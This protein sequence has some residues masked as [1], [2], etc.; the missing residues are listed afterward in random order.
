VLLDSDGNGGLLNSQQTADI[1]LLNGLAAW[2]ATQGIYRVHPTLLRALLETPIT[3]DLPADI[4]KRLPEWCLYVETPGYRAWDLL[5]AGFWAYLEYDPNSECAELRLILDL[6]EINRLGQLVIRLGGSLYDG[7]R[8]ALRGGFA[9]EQRLNYPE[10]A[11]EELPPVG[12]L[13]SVLLYLCAEEREI[14]EIDPR[15]PKFV[16]TK[17]GRLILPTPERPKVHECGYRIGARLDASTGASTESGELT[18]AKLAPHVRRAHWH[19][20]WIGPRGGERRLELR[21]L[22]PMLVGGVPGV[23]VVRP[24]GDPKTSTDG[25]SLT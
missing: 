22:S 24:V 3:G 8:A 14:G 12:G 1:G 10:L 17:K 19:A 11:N 18:G 6:P 15:P 16:R 4:L 25:F 23:A 21:W 9:Q 7:L 5:V 20:Y 2:R 13:V